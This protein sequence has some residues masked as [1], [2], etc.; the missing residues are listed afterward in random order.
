CAC[1]RLKASASLL[2]RHIVPATDTCAQARGT[3]AR[4]S[5]HGPR[6]AAC[7]VVLH[8]ALFFARPV[9]V[10]RGIAFVVQFFAA[11]QTKVELDTA[12]TVVQIQRYQ[13]VAALFYF[14]DQLADFFC[15]Q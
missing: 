3:G 9:F 2:E 15:V 10:A 6:L 14:T 4:R 7:V 1:C 11:S 5:A 8:E 13:R 12:V